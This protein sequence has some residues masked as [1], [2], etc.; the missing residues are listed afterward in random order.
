MIKRTICVII[1]IMILVSAVIPIN[2]ETTTPIPDYYSSKNMGYTT[3]VKNQGQ[4]GL[5]WAYAGTTIL[6][7]YLNKNGLYAEPLS[8]S[9]LDNWA[10][11]REDGSG[12]HRDF[13]VT[14]GNASIVIGYL[15]SWQGPKYESEFP[16]DMEKLPF[17]GLLTNSYPV[18]GVTSIS[19][20]SY[21]NSNEVKSAIMEYGAVWT[22]YYHSYDYFGSDNLSYYNQDDYATGGHAVAIIGWDDNYSKENFDGADKP[23]QNGAW[24]VQNSWGDYHNGDGYFYMSYENTLFEAFAITGVQK[25][26]DNTILYQNEIFG[27]TDTTS[28]WTTGDVAYMNIFD[29]AENTVLDKIMFSYSLSDVSYEIY[30][31]PMDTTNQNLPTTNTTKWVKLGEGVTDHEG[32]ICH[33]I[34]DKTVPSGNGAIAINILPNTT[35]NTTYSVGILSSNTTTTESEFVVA[36]EK[37]VENSYTISQ[38]G[39]FYMCEPITAVVGENY[40]PTFVIKAVAYTDD[41]QE[42]F[43]TGDVNKDNIIN[44]KDATLIQKHIIN[45]ITLDS[46][47]LALADY[48]NNNTV[49][50]NDVVMIQKYS[51]GLIAS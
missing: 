17:D 27:S 50:G 36:P 42:T 40:N 3:T 28:A 39:S 32:M 48:D 22:S 41:N 14:G 29:F 49:D 9:H 16:Y 46:D 34:S 5:C 43:A 35:S 38:Y 10:I 1:S 51:V 18:Y 7:I 24:I 11:P 33:D 19:N 2:A 26:E 25:I 44:V 20:L 37:T 21:D 45:L 12:W 8:V 31:I 4:T 15:T 13:S 6:E 30:Y 47:V 23:T